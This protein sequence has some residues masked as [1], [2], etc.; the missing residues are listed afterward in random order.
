MVLKKTEVKL[1]QNRYSLYPQEKMYV[2][3][4]MLK[5]FQKTQRYF[6]L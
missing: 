5:I 1:R 3:F 2:T 6:P 4:K